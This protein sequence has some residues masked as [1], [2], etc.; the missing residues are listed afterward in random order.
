MVQYPVSFSVMVVWS[1][2]KGQGPRARYDGLALPVRRGL[3]R[4][5]R[6]AMA[7]VHL[8]CDPSRELEEAGDAAAFNAKCGDGLWPAL[9]LKKNRFF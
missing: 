7:Q 3:A 4:A 9:G 6:L 1:R 5:A 8:S 2:Y